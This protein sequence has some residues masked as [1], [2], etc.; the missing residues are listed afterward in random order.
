MDGY[1]HA[2]A[3]LSKLVQHLRL[4]CK[5][6]NLPAG[7]SLR[8]NGSQPLRRQQDA[9]AATQCCL[10]IL[11]ISSQFE[12]F[13]AKLTLESLTHTQSESKVDFTQHEVGGSSSFKAS[14]GFSASWDSTVATVNWSGGVDFLASASTTVTR[15]K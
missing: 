6:R 3:Y 5:R 12:R 8:C 13:Q 1:S 10:L 7:R 14:A 15:T 4:D 9:Q 2:K 11:L